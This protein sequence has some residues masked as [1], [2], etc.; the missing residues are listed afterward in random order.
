M[1]GPFDASKKGWV[2]GKGRTAVWRDLPEDARGPRR[3]S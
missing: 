3:N 2:R 1:I